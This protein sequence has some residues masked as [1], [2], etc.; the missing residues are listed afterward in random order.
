MSAVPFTFGALKRR[1]EDLSPRE[2]H[3]VFGELPEALQAEAWANLREQ[4]DWRS[5][6]DFEDWCG[7]DR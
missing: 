1:T 4:T 5:Q 7:D 2:Q 3:V 6:R